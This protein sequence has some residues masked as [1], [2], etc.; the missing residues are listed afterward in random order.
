MSWEPLKTS[1]AAF[2][3]ITAALGLRIANDA[4]ISP[5][6]TLMRH[7]LADRE[8]M[9][10]NDLLVKWNSGDFKVFNDAAIV[11]RRFTDA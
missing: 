8:S 9:S 1:L 2:N 6:L 5:Q 10:E 11:V 3:E 7:F 4:P